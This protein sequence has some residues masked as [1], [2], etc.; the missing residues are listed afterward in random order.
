MNTPTPRP[1]LKA[2]G[3]RRRDTR[4]P[5]K[6]GRKM[7][8]PTPM[9]RTCG[10]ISCDECNDRYATLTAER[11]QLRA[12]CEKA[13]KQFEILNK[14]LQHVTDMYVTATRRAERVEAS[15]RAIFQWKS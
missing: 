12:D 11:D 13:K 10:E 5:A 9:P 4:C 14:T 15:I 2:T 8:T 7:S 6:G 1:A 3:V